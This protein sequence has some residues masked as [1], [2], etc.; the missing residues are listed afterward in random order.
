MRW[1]LDYPWVRSIKDDDREDPRSVGAAGPKARIGVV[2]YQAR[3][4]LEGIYLRTSLEQPPGLFDWVL[5]KP[6]WERW[7]LTSYMTKGIWEI[8][9]RTSNRCSTDGPKGRSG[10]V[11][12]GWW[13]LGKNTLS[14]MLDFFG[15][16]IS[17]I[18]HTLYWTK[19]FCYNADLVHRVASSPRLR[20]RTSRESILRSLLGA[21]PLKTVVP[22]PP[23]DGSSK[24]LWIPPCIIMN[25]P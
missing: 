18:W 3:L 17:K 12:I 13:W 6:L 22:N 10:F 7:V 11:K 21:F 19:V 2:W 5:I 16:K 20:R 1:P 8:S 14:I 4:T 15:S 9:S 25:S 24:L 23:E